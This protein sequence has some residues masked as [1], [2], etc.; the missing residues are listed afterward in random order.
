LGLS[1]RAYAAKR[2][3]SHTAVRKALAAGRI[4]ALE[5]GSIDPERADR[6]WEANTDRAQQRGKHAQDMQADSAAAR[7]RMKERQATEKQLGTIEQ[8]E[9]ELR[10]AGLDDAAGGEGE[11]EALSFTV[12]RTRKELLQVKLLELKVAENEGR[13][14]DREKATAVV[15]DLARR[16]RDA[17]LSW[18]ARVGALIAGEFDVDPHAMEQALGRAV[19]EHMAELAELKVE[20]RQGA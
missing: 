16:E 14:V 4:T 18:P 19:R 15:F 11:D 12:A 17:W 13:L 3:C 10:S 6:E 8:L 7:R 20:F 2:G 9:E 1:I 5:D